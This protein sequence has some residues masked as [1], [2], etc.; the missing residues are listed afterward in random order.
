MTGDD[1][2]APDKAMLALE[3]KLERLLAKAKPSKREL[4]QKTFRGLFPKL[5]AYIDTGMPLK[6]V[7]TAFN[8]LVESNV[9]ARTFNEWLS[10]EREFRQSSDANC[11][12]ACGQPLNFPN[13]EASPCEAVR[14]LA[15]HTQTLEQE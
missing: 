7:R 9:C 15:N 10:K 6:D 1:V 14:Q 8:S 4:T 2:A 12:Y 11:C 5:Q 3:E 13:D